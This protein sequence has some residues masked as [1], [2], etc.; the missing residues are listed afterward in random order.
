M[1]LSVLRG[2]QSPGSVWREQD[3][4]LAAAL[5]QYEAGL[6]AGCGHPLGESAHE[7]SDPDNR[8]GTHRYEAPDPVRCFACDA[9][10]AKAKQYEKNPHPQALRF[11]TV[12]RT[13]VAGRR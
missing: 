1:P 4:L 8:E 5:V 9:L 13:R 7:L 12:R 2:Y 11:A 10:A 6:C 3:G